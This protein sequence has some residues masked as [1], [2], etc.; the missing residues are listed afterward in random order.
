[1]RRSRSSLIALLMSC[2]A[3]L[4]SP[5]G[6]QAQDEGV[7]STECC[8]DMLAPVGARSISLGD[9]LTARPGEDAIFINPA[10][11]AARRASQAI[12]HR[13]DFGQAKRTTLGV[14]LATRR[15]GVFGLA[16]HLVDFGTQENTDDTGNVLGTSKAISTS[17]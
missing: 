2:A 13:S 12:A 6:L 17:G 10:G 7:S 11:I 1:M 9:A 8:I 15:A 3:L 16:Y 5:Y 4:M 14:L